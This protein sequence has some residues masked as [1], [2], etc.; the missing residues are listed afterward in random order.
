MDLGTVLVV[1]IGAGFHST[2]L[3]SSYR[4]LLKAALRC[5]T[6]QSAASVVEKSWLTNTGRGSSLDRNGV[7]SMDATYLDIKAG[8][9]HR[10]LS[11]TGICDD[12]PTSAIF[13]AN[14]WLESQ[15]QKTSLSTRLGLLRPLCLR[16]KEFLE[17]AQLKKNESNLVRRSAVDAYRKLLLLFNKDTEL[18]VSDVNIST[19]RCKRS[20]NLRSQAHPNA[21]NEQNYG[22][23]EELHNII[24][25]NQTDLQDTIGIVEIKPNADIGAVTSSGGNFFKVPGR[26]S[27]A[28]IIGTG[29]AFSRLSQVRVVAMASG[30]GDDIIGMGLAAHICD[31]VATNYSR[32]RNDSEDIGDFVVTTIENRSHQCVLS[33]VDSAGDPKIYLG[34]IVIIVTPQEKRLVFCHSTESFYFGIRRGNDIE[35]IMS[36][37]ERKSGA[38]IYGEYKL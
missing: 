35:V 6:F 26:I 18:V 12:S 14:S 8:K 3:D 25:L 37:I 34:A 1:H 2:K 17:Y 13:E 11:L 21:N 33:T 15:F 7:A 4:K 19:H 9:V 30:N 10:A 23:T 24:D 20:R 29:V 38:F 28:G 36:R 22:L 5:E 32:L 16:H 27:C 31:A